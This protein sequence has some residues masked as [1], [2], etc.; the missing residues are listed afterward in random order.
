M[1]AFMKFLYY[2]FG[3]VWFDF[4]IFKTYQPPPSFKPNQVLKK[5]WAQKD[6]LCWIISRKTFRRK[7]SGFAESLFVENRLVVLKIFRTVCRNYSSF[8]SCISDI[9]RSVSNFFL[10]TEYLLWLSLLLRE[11]QYYLVFLGVSI[12]FL[13]RLRCIFAVTILW[14][15]DTP[16]KEEYSLQ[17]R[18]IFILLLFRI[19]Y[20]KIIYFMQTN[21]YY[22]EIKQFKMFVVKRWK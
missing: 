16:L 6:L 3:L 20:I 22:W 5:G 14:L 7:K 11:A 1:L 12:L 8:G 19:M 21:Y 9:S 18:T 4:F 13:P 10:V 17:F 15:E 2:S